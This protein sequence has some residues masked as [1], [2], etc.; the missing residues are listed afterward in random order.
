MVTEIDTT[1][2]TDWL[3]ANA[4][5]V[6]FTLDQYHQMIATGFVRE[7]APIEFI[8]GFLV[9]KDRSKRGSDPMTVCPAHG[10]SI[11]KLD[12]LN[13][14]LEPL[15]LLMR[16]QQPI[17]LPPSHEPEPDGV[18]AR[19]AID[20]YRKRH[21]HAPD[22][23]CVI[24]VADSSLDYDRTTK[25]RVYASAGI[26]QYVIINLPEAS[27]DVYEGPHGEPARYAPPVRLGRSD[28][29]RFNLGDGRTLEVEC[30]ALLPPPDAT[31]ALR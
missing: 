10:W 12:R 20:D 8:D 25:Q 22:I 24:E 28:R 7:G 26:P 9:L 31:G 30:A 4:S 18:V 13:H 2:S 1:K 5:M 17:T 29:V 23:T 21:P 27:V 14:R 11:Q 3:S 15:G 16:T 19:G 6:R